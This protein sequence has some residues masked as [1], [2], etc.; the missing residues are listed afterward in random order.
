VSAAADGDWWM[1]HVLVA[2]FVLLVAAI[3]RAVP[4]WS[5]PLHA[6]IALAGVVIALLGVHASARAIGGVARRRWRSAGAALLQAAALGAAA[7]VLVTH[8]HARVTM[9]DEAMS[10]ESTADAGSAR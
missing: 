6:W 4:G 3:L 2:V 10:P 7:T 1:A 5:A 9:I 8:G